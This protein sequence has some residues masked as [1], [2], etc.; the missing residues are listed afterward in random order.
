MFFISK[1]LFRFRFI[2]RMKI[3]DHSKSLKF[4]KMKKKQPFPIPPELQ[5][6]I[7][8]DV[9]TYFR[10]RKVIADGGQGSVWM[11][12]DS[13]GLKYAIKELRKNA[14][15]PNRQIKRYITECANLLR[16]EHP[17]VV[18][19]RAMTDR[20]P[21]TIITE[22][23]SSTNL[24]KLLTKNFSSQNHD[25]TIL[26]KIAMSVANAMMFLHQ[27]GIIHRDLK[28]S[29]IL[30]GSNYMPKI[31]DFGYVREI[32]KDN[33]PT[34]QVGTPNWMAPEVIRGEEYTE[35]CDVFS[36][37]MILFE[38]ATLKRPLEQYEEEAVMNKY[39][40]D[41]YRPSFPRK[42]NVPEPLKD[43][44]EQC[45]NEKPKKRPSFEEIFDRFANS[46]VVFNNTDSSKIR[47]FAKQLRK[48]DKKRRII[49]PFDLF[50]KSRHHSDSDHD[51]KHDVDYKHKGKISSRKNIKSSESSN[52]S[53]IF[54]IHTFKNDNVHDDY[55]KPSKR[56]MGLISDPLNDDVVNHENAPEFD[57]NQKTKVSKKEQVPSLDLQFDSVS[58]YESNN[59]DESDETRHYYPIQ[60]T[61]ISV[62]VLSDFRSP[63]FQNEL[64]KVTKNNFN[65]FLVALQNHL[66]CRNSSP[67]ALLLL[68]KKLNSMLKDEDCLEFFCKTNIVH[69]LPYNLGFKISDNENDDPL[70]SYS[71]EILLKACKYQPK[72]IEDNF[73]SKMIY[74][75]NSRPIEAAT[76]LQIYAKAFKTIVNPWPLLDLLITEKKKFNKSLAGSI[77]VD[78]LVD[79]LENCE[80]YIKSRLMNCKKV[81]T[82]FIKSPIKQNS[83]EAYKAI[84]LFY[85]DEF[86]LP[87]E[88]I[89]SDLN[90]PKMAPYVIGL[91]RK[92][93]NV[94]AVPEIL[95]PLID[96]AKENKDAS[97]AILNMT[98]SIDIN[99]F[100]INN[101]K[102]W[103]KYPLPTYFDTFLILL[104]CIKKNN[105]KQ[106]VASDSHY[107]SN[108]FARSATYEVNNRT[109]CCYEKVFDKLALA[110]DFI[111]ELQE[112]DFFVNF[113]KG[114]IQLKDEYSAIS[115]V[116]LLTKMIKIKNC[117]EYGLF[118]KTLQRFASQTDELG[119]EANACIRAMK[120]HKK[121]K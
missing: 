102:K 100:L 27:S 21:L 82:F 73:E 67:D 119:S 116:R 47:T 79:L 37:A 24:S 52:S 44:I 34:C 101:Q 13:Q 50:P 46:E 31:C 114:I 70:L 89:A 76:I 5:R 90:D 84:S 6:F 9:D 30:I 93:E 117:D 3:L 38:M 96:L 108:L 106:L 75:I 20:Y 19:F 10:K 33:H 109:Y 97:E 12:T 88:K 39:A 105:F 41:K 87:F 68:L 66:T 23:V 103:V 36:Y 48:D 53:E 77:V 80:D 59:D 60:P 35:K 63:L 111:V 85:D 64:E 71:V 51:Q 112:R 1:G 104:K 69:L 40:Y 113:F 54:T 22:Y 16:G 62:A 107:V 99:Q 78:T 11:G 95:L 57:F 121:R 29:N 115:G 45:W 2:A 14:K 42:S 61:S 49:P 18:C 8:H 94:P 65:K 26:T 86:D 32:N 28:P 92:I 118:Y 4:S 25:G 56:K 72:L 91:F 43:L 17:F 55:G 58:S 98:K 15:N 74:I 120:S 83:I 110:E 7:I 81:F